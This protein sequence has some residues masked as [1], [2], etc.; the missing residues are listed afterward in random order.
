MILLGLGSNLAG[1]A[2]TPA[3]MLAVAARTLREDGC[4]IIAAS[5]VYIS[6]PIGPADQPWFAN[7]VLAIECDLSPAAL[8]ALCHR[9]EHRFERVRERR[10]HARTLDIDLLDW[11]GTVRPDRAA[12]RREADAA[13]A[14]DD[15]VLPYPR[16]HLRRFVLQP[17]AD[18]A[19][20]WRHPVL[21]EDVARL[22]RSVADQSLRRLDS[23]SGAV[24]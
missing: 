3:D 19:P 2:R 11:H 12:W 9:I 20:G 24:D 14:P 1:R 4:K 10:W 6:A 22:L 21:G 8:L 17:L 18:I 16:L 5:P 13:H 23:A 7:S 15:L